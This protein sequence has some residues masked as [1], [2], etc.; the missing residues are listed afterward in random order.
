MPD[1]HL[2]MIIIF[3]TMKNKKSPCVSN[4]IKIMTLARGK[5]ELT[6]KKR[7]SVFFIL[8]AID[9]IGIRNKQMLSPAM[10]MCIIQL[11]G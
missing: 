2:W 7:W 5:R 3:C 10:E 1:E 11:L 4:V 6:A 9:I 8:K